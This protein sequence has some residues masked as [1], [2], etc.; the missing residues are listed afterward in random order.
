MEVTVELR[1]N[2]CSDEFVRNMLPGGLFT[3]ARHLDDGSKV[4]SSHSNILNQ[5]S[6]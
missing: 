2:S 5:S 6:L 4:V 3:Y 1:T